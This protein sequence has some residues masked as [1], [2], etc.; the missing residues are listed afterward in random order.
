M[1]LNSNPFHPRRI[2]LALAGLAL[3]GGVQIQATQGF[4]DTPMVV[5]APEYHV[6]DPARPGCRTTAIRSVSE[7]SGC[8][9]YRIRGRIVLLRAV[10]ESP[11][12]QMVTN[13]AVE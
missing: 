10:A 8:V 11:L 3:V 9:P 2:F 7:I 13:A 1:K 12:R 5:D 4:S 6:H